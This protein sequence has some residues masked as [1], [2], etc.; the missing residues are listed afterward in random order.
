MWLPLHKA[1]QPN[2]IS[3]RLLNMKPHQ[4][5][6]FFFQIWIWFLQPS[7]CL[8]LELEEHLPKLRA[9]GCSSA[10]LPASVPLAKPMLAWW[11]R[12]WRVLGK[13]ARM[14]FLMHG[15]VLLMKKTKSTL[16][17]SGQNVGKGPAANLLA[18]LRSTARAGALEGFPSE[19]DLEVR[20]G[21]LRR[22]FAGL[23]CPRVCP[24]PF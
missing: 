3:R 2:S 17:L 23:P 8:F 4:D 22:G 5:F 10:L 13:E 24:S 1:L 7:G 20:S 6:F 21:F 18:R 16:P 12:R 14:L 9:L 15:A 19:Q 11:L